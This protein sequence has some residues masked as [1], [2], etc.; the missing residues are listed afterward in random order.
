MKGKAISRQVQETSKDGF[1]VA[2]PLSKWLNLVRVLR[3]EHY[4]PMLYK[5]QKGVLKSWVKGG[6][7]S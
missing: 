5:V 3:S 1:Y 4:T 6:G 2:E 7:K